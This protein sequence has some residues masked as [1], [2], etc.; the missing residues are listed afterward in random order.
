MRREQEMALRE[1]YDE[2]IARFQAIARDRRAR[3]RHVDPPSVGT[4]ASGGSFGETED[5]EELVRQAL[6]ESH[7]RAE[8]L[9]DEDEDEDDEDYRPPP[10]NPRPAPAPSTSAFAG[11]RV[12]DDDDAEL[13]AALKASLEGAPEGFVVPEFTTPSPPSRSAPAAPQPAPVPASPSAHTETEDD[14]DDMESSSSFVAEPEPEE[15]QVSVDEMRR[16][17]LA[18]FGG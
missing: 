3:S 12:Y 14:T 5:E 1:G 16:R 17:R 8:T 4:S 13:Q 2:E 7:A 9:L 11:H 10:R 6:T 18:R 15:E